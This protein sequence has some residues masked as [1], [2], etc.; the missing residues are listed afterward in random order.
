MTRPFVDLPKPNAVLTGP[1]WSGPVRVLRAAR[2]GPSIRIEAVGLADSKYYDLTL[3]EEQFR[4]LVA[5]QAGGAYTFDASPRLFRLA[6]KAL[7]THLAH[8]FDP[9]YAV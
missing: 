7:R 6:T 1:F 9:Q 3:T 4:E 2:S 8:A 5:E